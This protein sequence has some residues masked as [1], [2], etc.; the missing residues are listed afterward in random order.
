MITFALTLFL[1][2]DSGTDAFLWR[3]FRRRG[4]STAAY[5]AL[6]YVAVR[7][8]VIAACAALA[9]HLASL[10][11]SGPVAVWGVL[12]AAV[13]T[14]ALCHVL[15]WTAAMDTPYHWWLRLFGRSDGGLLDGEDHDHK[16]PIA[17]AVASDLIGDPTMDE[18]EYRTAA[19][20]SGLSVLASALS[21]DLA[22]VLHA[23]L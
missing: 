16:G 13:L 2:V 14:V 21:V 18:A 9:H 8:P 20:A 4:W 10:W 17:P 19:V 3:V 12:L 23:L 6:R 15:I 7:L 5:Q 11:L 22:L 1:T